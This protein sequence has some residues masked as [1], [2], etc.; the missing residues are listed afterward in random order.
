[1]ITVMGATGHTGKAISETLLAA[2]EKVRA[3][4]RSA[5]K[6]LPGLIE[7]MGKKS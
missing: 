4:G 1:M 2:G 6:L 3:L 5:E 7:T